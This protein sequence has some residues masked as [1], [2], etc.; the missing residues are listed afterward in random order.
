MYSLSTLV[1]FREVYHAL[2]FTSCLIVGELTTL[3]LCL[4]NRSVGLIEFLNRHCNDYVKWL[5][6]HVPEFKAFAH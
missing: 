2:H 4:F 6:N 1:P 5:L 3:N